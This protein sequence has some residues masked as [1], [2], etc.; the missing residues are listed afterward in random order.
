MKMQAPPPEQVAG[1]KRPV[2]ANNSGRPATVMVVDDELMNLKLIEAMLK[3]LGYNVILAHDGE[4]C[5]KRVTEDRPDLI[6]LD[7]MMPR[8][9]GFDVATL[10]KS[11]P[12]TKLIPIVIVTTLQNVNDRVRALEVGADDF[13]TKPVDR[14]ELRARVSSLLK[15]KAYNDY[16]VDYQQ[17]LEA[18]VAKRTRLLRITN[19]KLFKSSLETIHRLSRAAEYKDEDTGA[20]IIRMSQT[21]SL[22]AH[23]L[24]LSD[25]VAERILYAAPM[26]DVGKIGIPDRILL[27]NGPLTSEEWIIMKQH[28]TFG[29]KILEGSEVSFI[30]LAEIIAL[31]H[32]EKW[33]GSGYPRGLK[34]PEI[35]KVG[36]IVAVAD[37]FDALMSR[38]PYKPPFSLDK[39]LRIMK[40]GRGSHFDPEVLDAFMNAVP[41]VL[42][43]WHQNQDPPEAEH[44]EQGWNGRN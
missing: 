6:L 18:E 41:E 3:P 17:K 11:R 43:I 27:K 25:T 30:R 2:A 4:E 15:V 22:L 7:I 39:V 5:L 12:D 8:L 19:D 32:H 24:G 10:L 23:R 35:P 44:L 16:M 1:P 31:T 20:H 14:L 38:R 28:T 36:R 42:D 13:L 26:H 34:G 33:D 40:E 21:S 9:N 37:V 29:G